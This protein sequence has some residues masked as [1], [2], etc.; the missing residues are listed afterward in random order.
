MSTDPNFTPEKD[1]FPPEKTEPPSN[2]DLEAHGD[3]TVVDISREGGSA[4]E[5]NSNLVGWDEP[6]D[7]DPA[8]PQNW[9]KRRKWTQVF[10]LS[11]IT[12]LT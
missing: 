8:N 1:A 11:S 9:T 6:E 2:F 3:N 10:I 7:Q 5:S 4:P 12:F